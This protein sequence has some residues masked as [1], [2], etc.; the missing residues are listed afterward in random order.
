M[1]DILELYHEPYDPNYPV[2][3]FDEMP[4]CMFKDVLSALPMKPGKV[5]RFDYEF[6]RKGVC[7][8]FI[9]F[10]P[11]TGWRQVVVFERRRK[12]EL[13]VCLEKIVNEW[14]PEARQIRLVC[15]NL[16]THNPSTLYENFDASEARRMVRKLDF[17]YTPKHGSWLNMA[18]LELSVLSRQCLK[19]RIPTIE[20]VRIACSAWS[21]K[22]TEKRIGVD[23]RFS[24]EDARD[25]LGRLYPK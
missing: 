17:R 16:N 6:E 21:E 24:V 23:W 5:E 12:K 4:Y 2:V 1:E 3:C 19:R 25:K 10:Q 8:I 11:L 22:R 14:F 7:N 20:D 13:A 18:E 9:F 15:D